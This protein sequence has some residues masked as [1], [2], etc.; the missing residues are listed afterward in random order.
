MHPRPMLSVIVPA[1]DEAKTFGVLMEALLR[2]KM[3]GLPMEII[4]VESN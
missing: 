1:Y 2:K 3:P 4:V